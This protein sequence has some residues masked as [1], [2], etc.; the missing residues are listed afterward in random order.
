MNKKTLY[1]I[2]MVAIV[3][4]GAG[5]GTYA[6]FTATRTTTANSFAAGTLDLNVD[7][8]GNVLEPF[9]IENIG[10][11]GEIGGSKTWTVTNTG[12][13]PGRFLVRLQNVSNSEN[14]CNDQ[15][16]MAEPACADDTQ[17]EMGNVIEL[18]ADYDGQANIANAKLNAAEYTQ[19]GSEWVALD[20][21]IIQP[22]EE[23][24]ITLSWETGENDYGNEIQSDSV[25]F[26]VNFRLIQQ[27]SGAAPSNI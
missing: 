5:V 4:S 16:E 13:L 3:A 14:G 12:S 24:E 22:G 27:I 6:Y 26:D 25:Q 1:S 11:N 19:L 20:P 21:M 18:K 10:E 2:F 23:K 9:V 8:N 15:E 17:G 7:S